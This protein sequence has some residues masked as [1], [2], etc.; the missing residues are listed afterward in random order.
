MPEG[1]L[2]AVDVTAFFFVPGFATFSMEIV[3]PFCF[4]IQIISSDAENFVVSLRP[5]RG[6][7]FNCTSPE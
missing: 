7:I 3:F 4:S 1:C 6:T 5:S 2:V